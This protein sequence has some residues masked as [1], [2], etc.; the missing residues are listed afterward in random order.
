MTACHAHFAIFFLF[1]LIL[2]FFLFFIFFL[3]FHFSLKLFLICSY[4]SGDLSLAVLINPRSLLEK[5]V[6]RSLEG[7]GQSDPP[8]TFDTIHPIVLKFGKYNKLHLYFQLS[9]STWCLIGFHGNNNQINDAT[10]S[11]HLGF[12]NFVQIFTFLPQIDGKTAFSG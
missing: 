8:S 6:T 5:I 10:G 9:E 7:R 4:F 1:T 2:L 3:N 12:S 11:R